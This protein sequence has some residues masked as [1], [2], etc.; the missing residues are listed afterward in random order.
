MGIGYADSDKDS[1]W[2][3]DLLLPAKKQSSKMKPFSSG[4]R[5]AQVVAGGDD[6]A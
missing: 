1:F 4:I 5:P 3:L 6:A 2:D